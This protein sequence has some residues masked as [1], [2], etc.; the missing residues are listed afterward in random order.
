MSKM[1]VKMENL[2]HSISGE[3][4]SSW[5]LLAGNDTVEIFQS[6]VAEV[7]APAANPH[8]L[9]FGLVYY[10]GSILPI[11]SLNSVDQ[12]ILCVHYICTV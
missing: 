1:E 2:L 8:P 5:L 10:C 6:G 12:D 4:L 3:I 11:S 9:K 7:Y